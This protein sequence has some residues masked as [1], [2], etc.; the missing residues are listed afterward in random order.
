MIIGQSIV[1]HSSDP[2]WYR[3]YRLPSTYSVY[4][5][6]IVLQLHVKHGELVCLRLS[7]VVFSKT[8]CPVFS[9]LQTIQGLSYFCTHTY[10]FSFHF[11][12]HIFNSLISNPAI[13]TPCMPAGY[14]TYSARDFEYL[15]SKGVSFDEEEEE[16]EDGL[17]DQSFGSHSTSGRHRGRRRHHRSQR[18][19]LQLRLVVK[20]SEA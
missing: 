1:V 3:T 18:E 6:H 8:V 4:I 10:L 20:E 2:I 17:G 15:R 5:L 11:F 19:T 16:E 14:D 9:P 7:C 12:Y 13:W